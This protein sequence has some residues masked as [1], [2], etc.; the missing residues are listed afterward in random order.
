MFYFSLQEQYHNLWGKD[1]K[2]KKS[3]PYLLIKKQAIKIISTV[4]QND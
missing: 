2:R 3:L 1:K 4:L